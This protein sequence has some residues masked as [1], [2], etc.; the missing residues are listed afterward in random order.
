MGL[1]HQSTATWTILARSA[2]LSTRH[3]LLPLISFFF[4]FYPF[5]MISRTT[6][7]SG[8]AGPIFAMFLPNE[9]ILGGDD[10]SRPI[11]LISLGTL[12]W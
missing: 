9:S 11:F 1:Y 7:I 12:P 4:R 3:I 2:K 6:I 5:L 10:R 8:S